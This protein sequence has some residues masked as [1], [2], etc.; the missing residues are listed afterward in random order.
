MCLRAVSPSRWG[1]RALGYLCVC[2]CVCVLDESS[3]G[4]LALCV[5]FG[6]VCCCLCAGGR[7]HFRSADYNYSSLIVSLEEWLGFQ[8]SCGRK[9]NDEAAR[10]R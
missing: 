2:V 1:A 5:L 6:F 3:L 8:G 4:A 9:M 7:E 10:R